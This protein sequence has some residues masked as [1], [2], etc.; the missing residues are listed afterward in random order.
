[1]K[2]KLFL[3]FIFLFLPLTSQALGISVQPAELEMI[4]P[5]KSSD[6][7][8]IKNISLEPITV[9]IYFDAF[10][11]E[12]KTNLSELELLPEESAR[13]QVSFVGDKNKSGV[14]KTNLSLLAR[15]MD[16]KKFNAASGLKIPLTIYMPGSSFHW[17]WPTIATLVF[18]GFLFL[19]VVA[20]FFYYFFQ[21]KKRKKKNLWQK[22]NFLG[23]Y[24]QKKRFFPWF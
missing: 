18:F 7:L 13:V 8:T 6:Y 23:K 22:I 14:Q 21:F 9:D 19:L 2:L 5:E 1:M 20:R 15:N 10:S 11:Q 24:R 4:I 12:L 16:Q 3:A 17:T